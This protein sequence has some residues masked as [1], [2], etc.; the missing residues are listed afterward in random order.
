MRDALEALAPK[1][2]EV[3]QLILDEDLGQADLA[4]RLGIPVG[5]VKTRIFYG[6]RALRVELEETRS[7]D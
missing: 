4:E 1:Q 6:L 5:T 2:R 3:L 7:P